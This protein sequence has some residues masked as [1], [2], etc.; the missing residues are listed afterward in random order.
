MMRNPDKAAKRA[1]FTWDRV[2]VWLKS[3]YAK[4]LLVLLIG[5]LCL[6]GIFCAAIVP[7]R[8]DLRVGSIA[9]KT[10]M[11]SKD[12]VDEVTT[13]ARRQAAANAVEPT[14]H[15]KEGASEDVMNNLK[16]VFE[17]L[18]AENADVKFCKVNVNKTLGGGKSNARKL[19]IRLKM[20]ACCRIFLDNM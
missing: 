4:S 15:L 11:A 1:V 9:H 13:E 16:D 17:E 12:V 7:E 14:Y 2:I 3:V 6:I 20:G 5:T 18:A 10:I 8:Y 19:Y